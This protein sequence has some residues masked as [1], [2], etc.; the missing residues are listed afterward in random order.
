MQKWLED[1]D[2][3]MYSIHDEGNSVVGKSLIRSLNG[4]AYK[5]KKWQ[6]IIAN[7]ILDVWS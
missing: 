5:K 7:L 1:N 3:L 6:M 2:I 4:K